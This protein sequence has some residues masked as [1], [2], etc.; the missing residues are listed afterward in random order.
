MS[1]SKGCDC[2][3]SLGGGSQLNILS[4]LGI[5]RVR[6]YSM[7]TLILMASQLVH[8][9]LRLTH[10][11]PF[12]ACGR[13]RCAEKVKLWKRFLNR[14]SNC[15]SS[16]ANETE[17]KT[18]FTVRNRLRTEMIGG[19]GRIIDGALMHRTQHQYS[20]PFRTEPYPW[21]TLQQ[22]TWPIRPVGD[23]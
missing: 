2:V 6:T 7:L 12:W 4:A 17:I 21:Q 8:T 5:F 18:A 10:S 20:T 15:L 14:F 16:M 3:G 19:L 23:S 11:D 9:S 22:G 1:G 13:H